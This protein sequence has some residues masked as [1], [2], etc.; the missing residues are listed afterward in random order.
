MM[1]AGLHVDLNCLV[2]GRMIAKHR[3]EDASDE[4]YL[5]A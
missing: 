5:I 3:V 2:S 4:G 1:R